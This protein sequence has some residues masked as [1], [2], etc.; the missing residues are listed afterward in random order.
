MMVY[1]DQKENY[2][3]KLRFEVLNSLG[4]EKPILNK[5]YVY[6]TVWMMFGPEM[7]TAEAIKGNWE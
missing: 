6:F 3:L 5:N 2:V 1:G 7:K 4:N